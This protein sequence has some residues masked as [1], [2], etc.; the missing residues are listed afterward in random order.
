M[1]YFRRSR[2]VENYKWNSNVPLH[3]KIVSNLSFRLR[4]ENPSHFFC[5][6]F[7]YIGI[8]DVQSQLIDGVRVGPS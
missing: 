3:T 7:K 5:C 2:H 1:H 6:M 8:K 4:A